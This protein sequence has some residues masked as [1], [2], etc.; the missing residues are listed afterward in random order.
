MPA[1]RKQ[2]SASIH[3]GRSCPVDLGKASLSNQRRKSSIRLQSHE[4][5]EFEEDDHLFTKVVISF[6][7]KAE[8]DHLTIKGIL[9][10]SKPN[11]TIFIKEEGIRLDYLKDPAGWM[12]KYPGHTQTFTEDDH[13]IGYMVGLLE[14]IINSNPY[15]EDRHD[16]Y[17]PILL[18]EKMISMEALMERRDPMRTALKLQHH[19]QEYA[20]RENDKNSLYD[21]RIENLEKIPGKFAVMLINACSTPM[22]VTKLMRLD[23]ETMFLDVLKSNNTQLVASKIY[24]KVVWKTFWGSVTS[25]E[26]SGGKFIKLTYALKRL[27]NFFV[28]NLSYLPLAFLSQFNSRFK[29]NIKRVDIDFFSPFCSYLA[30]LLNYCILVALLLTVCLT[31]VPDPTPVHLLLHQLKTG[32]ITADNNPQ[33]KVEDD[34]SILVK[35]PTPTIPFSEWSLWVCIFARVLTE[36]YQ[37]YQ[38]KGSGAKAKLLKYFNSFSNLT[39]IVLTL[40]LITG[41][42]CKLYV[43]IV[44]NLSGIYHPVDHVRM[45]SHRLVFT[46]Y[47]YSTA[48]AMAM[49]H[50]LEICT[51]HIPGLGPLLRAIRRM[52][53]EISRVM[54]LFGFFL[55]GFIVPMLSLASCYRAVHGIDGVDD[56]NDFYSLTSLSNTVL[57]LIWS[58]FSGLAWSHKIDLYNSLDGALTFFMAFLLILYEILLC[59]MCMN[60]LIAIM[61]DAYSKVNAD[62]SAHWRFAQFKSIMEYNAVT[63]IEGHG[64]PFL[65]PFCI[66]YIAF[67]LIT[68]TCK[69]RQL[70][71]INSGR[72]NDNHFAQFL[73]KRRGIYFENDVGAETEIKYDTCTSNVQM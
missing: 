14:I 30:D 2:P 53:A 20:Q 57:T 8:E 19:L 43:Y 26:Q 51:I 3:I 68:K 65:F 55:V 13:Y 28:W 45:V 10:C 1:N 17:S 6:A 11:S 48:T 15:G 22:E 60:L 36:W 44:S 31:T 32:N 73:C 38:K 42:V 56:R 63:N 47:L 59:N 41:M 54:F 18:L 12:S 50:V 58:L 5:E 67:N 27:T 7:E 21:R 33:F 37:A 72:R 40:L 49:V 9:A 16:I 66:P 25:A 35:L 52:F 61:C 62:R 29:K 70:K 24:Q 34:G 4:I 46:I 71:K 69:N 23:D 39:D 64:M